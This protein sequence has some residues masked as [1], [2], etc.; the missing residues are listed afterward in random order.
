MITLLEPGTSTATTTMKS[1][2]GVGNRR[3]VRLPATVKQGPG[4]GSRRRCTPAGPGR[5]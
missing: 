3:T 1:G 4:V 5:D 2:P